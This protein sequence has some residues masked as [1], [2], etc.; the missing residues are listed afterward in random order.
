MSTPHEQRNPSPEHTAIG[1][2]VGLRDKIKE[3]ADVHYG[4]A[5][6]EACAIRLALAVLAK[7]HAGEPIDDRQRQALESLTMGRLPDIAKLAASLDRVAEA[8]EGFKSDTPRPNPHISTD[9]HRVSDVSQQ[10][11]IGR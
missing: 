2:I 7:T 10:G 11:H 9:S 3:A 5:S 1:H 6:D 4:I 8:I